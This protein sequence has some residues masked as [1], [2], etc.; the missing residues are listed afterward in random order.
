MGETFSIKEAA[1]LWGLKYKTLQRKIWY[2][3]ENG[4]PLHGT[5]MSQFH[6][7]VWEVTEEYMIKNY[8]EQ[9]VKTEDSE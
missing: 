1:S 5:R 3:N 6:E 9:P 2:D 8:G 4:K 7:S